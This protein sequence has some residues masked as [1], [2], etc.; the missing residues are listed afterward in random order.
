M[1]LEAA[2]SKA[3]ADLDKARRIVEEAE[4]ACGTAPDDMGLA[5]LRAALAEAASVVATAASDDGAAPAD[6]FAVYASDGPPVP[7]DEPAPPA[8]VAAGPPRA[9]ATDFF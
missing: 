1:A 3:I 6:F 2:A 4:A 7:P 8:P 5:R 9:A